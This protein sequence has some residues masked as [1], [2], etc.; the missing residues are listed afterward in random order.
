MARNWSGWANIYLGNMDVAIEQFSAALRLSPLDP[1]LFLTQSGMAYA[2]FFAGRY[3]DGLSWATSAIQSQPNFPGG[4][5]TLTANL[6]MA[7]RIDEARRACDTC[8]KL[9]PTTRISG[10]RSMTPFRRPEDVEK[11]GQAYRIA[12]VPE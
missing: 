7:G 4:W 3:D 10:I 2:H 8:L 1:R 5:R 11:L 12:G 6:A 9:D